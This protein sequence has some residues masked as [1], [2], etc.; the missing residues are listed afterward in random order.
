VEIG[1]SDGKAVRSEAEEPQ[2]MSEKPR[3]P[4][5]R[6]VTKRR[7]IEALGTRAR[8]LFGVGF[9]ALF[10]FMA[11]SAAFWSIGDT[12]TRYSGGWW[13]NEIFR[14]ALA[15]WSARIT[16]YC[17]KEE[18]KVERVKFVTKRTSHLLPPEESL[19]RPSDLPPSRQQAELL[20]AAPQ[21][22]ETP[23][24]ELLRATTVGQE[25]D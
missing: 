3:K 14:L 1:R 20:R 11:F 2:T 16:Y 13:F 18:R 17:F 10:S 19:V 22:S 8:F 21:G 4:N 23:A 9:F 24:E 12:E 6:I 25:T 15:L 7:Y 5:K